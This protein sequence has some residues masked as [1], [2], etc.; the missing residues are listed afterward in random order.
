[1]ARTILKPGRNCQDFIEA[2]SSVILIDGRDYYRAFY[3]EACR[4]ESYICI[5]GWQFDSE[6]TLL[7]GPDEKDACGDLKFLNFLNQLCEGNKGLKIYMLAWDFSI[8]FMLEREWVQEWIFNWSTNGRL[9]FRFD[10]RHPVGASQHQKFAVI[11]GHAAFL[12]GMDICAGRWDDRR[13][14]AKNPGR[15]NP[16]GSG[17]EPYHDIQAYYTGP[18]AIKLSEIFKERWRAL[19][20]TEAEL[21]PAGKKGPALKLKE[22]DG[23]PVKAGRVSL[24]RTLAQTFVGAEGPIREIRLLYMD[25]IEA[26]ERL[27]YIENQYLSSYALFKA[28]M[29]RM[30]A[31]GRA[32]LQVII[33]LPKKPQ[34]FVEEVS[35]GAAQ[36]HILNS[37]R[38]AAKKNGHSL[39]VYYSASFDEKGQEAPVYIHSKLMMVDDRF[40]TIGSANATNRSFGLDSELNASC[41]AAA[42]KDYGLIESLRELR[43]GLLSEFCGIEKSPELY[44]VEGLV[45][46]LDSLAGSRAFRLKFHALNSAF[47]GSG[48]IR[49]LDTALLDPERAVIEENVFEIFS[50]DIR[51]LFTGGITVLKGWL[52]GKGG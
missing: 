5:S 48:L 12:G 25:A 14:L 11:D 41:E 4:A 50:P 52:L 37:L 3:R 24:S 39:G 46:Y 21:R 10:D 49:A 33:I 19:T 36:T 15:I 31:E 23:I 44:R 27:I 51:A 20:G 28:L 6:V 35:V 38:K 26:A 40:M 9:F 18:I 32:K 45:D 2:D 42:R 1:M 7:R 30:E 8:I 47:E 22:D 13:H 16:D 29:N 43:A 17:Y 34:A